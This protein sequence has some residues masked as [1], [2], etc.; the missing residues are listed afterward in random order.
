MAN[1][2]FART[3]LSWGGAFTA[4]QGV[5]SGGLSGVLMQQLG[6]NYAQNISQIHELGD[7]A[8][9]KVGATRVYYVGGRAQGQLQV[10]HVLGPGLA[11]REYY[12][13]FS[14]ICAAEANSIRINLTGGT[15]SGPG[16]VGA[17]TFAYLAKRC[18]L[19]NLGINVN[20]NDLV[21]NSNSALMFSNLEFAGS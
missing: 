9:G 8:P 16:Q 1:D 2:V 4:D 5:I 21:L 13:K 12:E 20:A 19:V 14:D 15:C 10:A 7:Y 6:L 18:V 3:Q 11:I 17:T